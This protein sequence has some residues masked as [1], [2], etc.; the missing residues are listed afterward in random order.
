M[1]RAYDKYSPE[2]YLIFISHEHEHTE[3]S[4]WFGSFF[5]CFR[6]R[7]FFLT[8]FFAPISFVGFFMDFLQA[9]YIFIAIE[10]VK[11]KGKDTKKSTIDIN[12]FSICIYS[13]PILKANKKA[14]IKM[15][16]LNTMI[17]KCKYVR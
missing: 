7:L 6:L 15:A 12:F 1:V 5:F 14:T 3:Y 2:F 9:P 16:S 13:I 4:N 11:K 17:W 8:Y 10:L